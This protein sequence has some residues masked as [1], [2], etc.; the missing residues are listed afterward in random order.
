MVTIVPSMEPSMMASNEQRRREAL[1]A[2]FMYQEASLLDDD[3]PRHA[4]AVGDHAEA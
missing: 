4:E 1:A 3:H 2:L